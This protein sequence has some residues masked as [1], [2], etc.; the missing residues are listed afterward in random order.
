[1]SEK[2]LKF[3][4]QCHAKDITAEEYEMVKKVKKVAKK[5]SRRE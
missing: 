4:A 5:T 3:K 1:V 2:R